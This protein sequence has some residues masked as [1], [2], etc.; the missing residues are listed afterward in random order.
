MQI[1][2]AH[3]HIG[4]SHKQYPLYIRSIDKML[5]VM[6]RYE[7]ARA[8]VSSLKAIQYDYREGN[9]EL[10]SIVAQFPERFIPFCVVHP[11]DWGVAEPELEKCITDWGWKALKLH[12][13]DQA[14]PA[15][16][17]SA[18]DII[19]RA[20][21]LGIVVAIHS[22]M[23]DCAHPCRIGNLARDF[24]E[25][26]FIMVHMGKMLYWTDALE[27]AIKYDNIILDT[28]DAM[29]SDGL[30]ETCVERIGPERL[31]CGTNLPVSYPGPNLERIR[32]ARIPAAQKEMIMGRN[33]ERILGL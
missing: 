19:A 27:E 24:P 8:C 20:A 26:T 15:D 16:C 23:D 30:V 29:F 31:V 11:R 28:T 9:R 14:F 22:S 33:I 10:K 25:T 4:F 13:V 2:D 5:E 21:E 18:R 6:D 1:V 17:L 3:A 7:I 32:I 12:P